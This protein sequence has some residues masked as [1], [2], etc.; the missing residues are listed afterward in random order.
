MSYASR[1]GDIDTG[2]GCYP[3]RKI[4]TGSS[5]V[6]VNGIPLAHVGSVMQKHDCKKNRWGSIVS[7]GVGFGHPSTVSSGSGTVSVN[8]FPVARMGDSIACGGVIEGG[9]NDVFIGG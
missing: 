7:R 4:I 8:G 2:H 6:T 9:S 3:P 5:N 1:I